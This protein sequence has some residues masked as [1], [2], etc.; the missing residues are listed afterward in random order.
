LLGESYTWWTFGW[1]P[2]ALWFDKPAIDLGV[3][4]KRDVMQVYTGGAYNVTGPGEAFINFGWF[5]LGVGAAL[6]ALYRRMEEVLLGGANVLRYGSFLLYPVLLYPF[7]QA[8][9]Q[10]SFSAFIVGAVAQS[11]LIIAMIILCVPRFSQKHAPSRSLRY[12]A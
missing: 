4:L 1:I 3:F 7:V 11:I 2:R 5:G 6:G 9:L 8:T 10:S 12:A